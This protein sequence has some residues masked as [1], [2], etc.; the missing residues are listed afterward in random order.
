MRL[1]LLVELA[2]IGDADLGRHAE[3]TRTIAAEAARATGRTPGERLVL[4]AA[5][6]IGGEKPSDPASAARQLLG[7]AAAP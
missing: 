3:A 4:V 6:V 7:A 1:E 5:H 2:F